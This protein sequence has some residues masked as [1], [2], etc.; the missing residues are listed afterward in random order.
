MGRPV[1]K[2]QRGDRFRI[3]GVDLRGDEAFV[4][5]VLLPDGVN[6][7]LRATEVVVGYHQEFEEVATGGDPGKGIP[8]ASGSDQDNA[9]W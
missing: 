4:G 2:D 8:H 6:R 7:P 9:H 5:P 1:L 3:R